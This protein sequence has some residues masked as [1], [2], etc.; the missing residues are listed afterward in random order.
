MLSVY[1]FFT[2]LTLNSAQGSFRCGECKAGFTGDQNTGC[3]GTR[4]CPNGQPNP[5][6][7]NAECV[8][9]R[10]GSISCM[11]RLCEQK[12]KYEYEYVY[13]CATLNSVLK[14]SSPPTPTLFFAC[15]CVCQCGVGW[16][17]NGY[18]CGKDTDID[19][20]P[21]NKLR[22]RDNNCIQVL[23]STYPTFSHIQFIPVLKK[24]VL[25]V[26]SYSFSRITVCLCQTLAKRMQTGM[27]WVTPVMMMQ[28]AMA[29]LT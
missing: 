16:A 12:H 25:L 1:C 2:F 6:D 7:I 29:L 26:F 21:D 11:V 20:Y 4:L 22:C 8:V 14:M 5:C 28:T 9:E 10:D 19:A 13:C 27:G 18:V 17:G 15:V 23:L 24:I 3:H